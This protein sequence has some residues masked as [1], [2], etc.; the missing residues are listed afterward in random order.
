MNT[1]LL[2]QKVL[3]LA[4]HGK[5]LD[6]AVVEALETTPGYEPA[7]KLLERIRGESLPLA[8]AGNPSSATPS[9][10]GKAPKILLRAQTPPATP[11]QILFQKMKYL[12]KF[13]RI[14]VGVELITFARYMEELVLEVILKM[15]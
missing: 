14:G 6:K 12:L 1:K 10:R 9:P 15:I 11:A 4:I 13:L 8:T 3:D 2:R 5:L 7:S